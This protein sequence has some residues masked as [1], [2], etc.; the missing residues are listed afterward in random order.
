MVDPQIG[1]ITF[2]SFIKV[3]HHNLTPY[4]NNLVSTSMCRFE[5]WGS[6]WAPLEEH[7]YYL[8]PSSTMDF[9]LGGKS[10]GKVLP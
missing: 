10:D 7:M 3:T 1:D 2:R 8:G 5:S 4:Y 6:F 9:T